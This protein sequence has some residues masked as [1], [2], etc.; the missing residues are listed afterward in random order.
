[1]SAPQGVSAGWLKCISLTYS[2][3]MLCSSVLVDGFVQISL[4]VCNL[5][6]GSS[7]PTKF[8][9][10]SWIWSRVACYSE[11][12]QQFTED[13]SSA[14]ESPRENWLAWKVC[15]YLNQMTWRMNDPRLGMYMELTMPLYFLHFGSFFLARSLKLSQIGWRV[16]VNKILSILSA[17]CR[18]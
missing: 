15:K 8:I 7:G 11:S 14:L 1:M 16:S 17:L 13:Y 10:G 3:H 18:A 2:P 5:D 12:H 4:Y 6:C 9:W